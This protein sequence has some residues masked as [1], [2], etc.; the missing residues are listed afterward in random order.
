M[1]VSSGEEESTGGWDALIWFTGQ[2]LGRVSF[3]TRGPKWLAEEV[4][5]PSGE[6]SKGLIVYIFLRIFFF[7]FFLPGRRYAQEVVCKVQ[8]TCSSRGWVSGCLLYCHVG[9]SSFACQVPVKAKPAV[10]AKKAMDPI[11]NHLQTC[12]GRPKRI[13][14]S[15]KKCTAHTRGPAPMWK[16]KPCQWPTAG[17]WRW[18]SSQ[19]EPHLPRLQ[20]GPHQWCIFQYIFGEIVSP[21][22]GLRQ[23]RRKWPKAAKWLKAAQKVSQ[24][25]MAKTS[26]PKR[27]G[28]TSGG[29][30]PQN[31][32]KTSVHER[33]FNFKELFLIFFCRDFSSLIPPPPPVQLPKLGPQYLGYWS[34]Y[35]YVCTLRISIGQGQTYLVLCRGGLLRAKG[36]SSTI[37]PPEKNFAWLMYCWPILWRDLSVQP[38]L[39]K[40][41]IRFSDVRTAQVQRWIS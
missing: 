22:T 35:P 31:L 9:W 39:E 33:F 30:A 5:L 18:H 36:W 21:S 13:W 20:G 4:E 6:S 37:R 23:M 14:M 29:L 1:V 38:N 2:N 41:N 10:L 7:D 34:I 8:A 24:L 12:T 26:L 28:N 19:L 27:K 16:P 25:L 15:W 40:W 32:L 3:S 11:A 17:K